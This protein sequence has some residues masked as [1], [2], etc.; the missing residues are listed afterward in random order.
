MDM[1]ADEGEYC[2]V[3]DRKIEEDINEKEVLGLSI[4]Q[5]NCTG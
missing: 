1:A 5:Q 4:P 3:S 2:L